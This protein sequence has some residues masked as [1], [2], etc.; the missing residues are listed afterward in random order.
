MRLISNHGSKLGPLFGFAA[1]PLALWAGLAR[2]LVILGIDQAECF[3]TL[4]LRRHLPYPWNFPFPA[5]AF[6]LQFCAS[7]QSYVCCNSRPLLALSRLKG[8]CL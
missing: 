7:R 3:Y 8:S 4:V 2:S 5:A 1:S 6:A